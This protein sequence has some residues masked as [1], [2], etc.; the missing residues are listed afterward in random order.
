M[1][2]CFLVFMV[3]RE[4]GFCILGSR[5]DGE[6]VAGRFN[7]RTTEAHERTAFQISRL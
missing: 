7:K 3:F 5:A 6:A 2:G 1:A 4:G